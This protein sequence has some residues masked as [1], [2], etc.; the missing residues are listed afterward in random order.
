MISEDLTNRRLRTIVE[1][2]TGT[3]VLTIPLEIA[4]EVLTDERMKVVELLKHGDM[5]MTEIAEETERDLP[6]VNRTVNKLV[7]LNIV[8]TM[9]DGK[10][11]YVTLIHDHILIEPLY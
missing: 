6:N 11:T 7:E 4:N 9:K 1:D 2:E 10:H 8:E 5:T 3:S